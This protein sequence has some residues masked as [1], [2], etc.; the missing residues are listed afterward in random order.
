MLMATDYPPDV[1][2]IFLDQS[3]VIAA[4]NELATYV[5]GLKSSEAS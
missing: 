3:S 2:G 4:A 1:E 5:T